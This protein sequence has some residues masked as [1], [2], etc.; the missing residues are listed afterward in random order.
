M[1][2]PVES[3]EAWRSGGEKLIEQLKAERDQLVDEIAQR[4]DRL[5]RVNQALMSAGVSSK[6]VRRLRRNGD[7]SV[8][9]NRTGWRWRLYRNGR[10]YLGPTVAD[11]QE[12]ERLLVEARDA[13]DRGEDPET[14]AVRKHQ[15]KAVPAEPDPAPAVSAPARKAKPSAPDP[16]R[17]AAIAAAAERTGGV[18][19]T[20]A[21]GDL[22]AI[23]RGIAKLPNR[24]ANVA[25]RHWLRGQKAELIARE[26]Q[27]TVKAVEEMLVEARQ[28]A[29]AADAA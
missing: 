26:L 4:R 2:D 24:L 11:P 13:L 9:P 17:I 12:A 8:S 3:F 25:R 16:G 22:Q 6:T 14:A 15:D 20:E 23:T 29:I 18:A 27:V 5:I 1:A 10:V 7:G 21:A 28:L 19:P